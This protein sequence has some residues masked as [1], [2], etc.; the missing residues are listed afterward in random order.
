MFS[1]IRRISYGVIPRPDR[2]W[3]EDATSNA[4]ARRKKRRLSSTERDERDESEE[5]S[6]S[7]KLRQSPEE[8]P[9]QEAT[10]ERDTPLPQP[11]TKE[12]KEV[13]QGVKEVDL[14]KDASAD[15]EASSAAPSDA[16]VESAEE[17]KK[18]GAEESLEPESIPLP[19][20]AT[21]ELD[22]LEDADS[23]EEKE[24][25]KAGE[26]EESKIEGVAAPVDGEGIKEKK[27]EKESKS[28]DAQD[29][30]PKEQIPSAEE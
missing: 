4:P 3:E 7:K 19:E 14:D 11:E 16:E 13:T 8:D 2:P 20:A 6:R 23:V 30:L 9:D 18:A 15:D 1:L 10:S 28:I 17:K 25:E 5:L 26:K 21:G 22:E 24:K 29:E 12:V 27:G